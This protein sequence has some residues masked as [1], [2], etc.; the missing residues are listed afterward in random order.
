VWAAFDTLGLINWYESIIAIVGDE[1]LEQYILETCT[2][3]WEQ[4]MLKELRS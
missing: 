1:F 2:G 3:E 4:P